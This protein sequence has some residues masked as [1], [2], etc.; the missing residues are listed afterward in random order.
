VS[1]AFSYLYANMCCVMNLTIA[2]LN[3]LHQ[4]SL[5]LFLLSS[6]TNYFGEDPALIG[7]ALASQGCSVTR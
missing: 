5:T 6:I 1:F 4:K 3:S 2:G 7:R